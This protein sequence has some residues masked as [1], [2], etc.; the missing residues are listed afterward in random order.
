[1]KR[2]FAAEVIGYPSNSKESQEFKGLDYYKT[3]IYD[4]VIYAFFKADDKNS[5][6][7]LV[8]SFSPELKLQE[9]MKLISSQQNL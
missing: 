6:T 8:K 9:P 2:L 5:N 3:I 7:L 4:N 1:M